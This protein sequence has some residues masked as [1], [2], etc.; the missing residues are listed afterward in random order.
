M[1]FIRHVDKYCLDH[2]AEKRDYEDLMNNPDTQII[3]EKL[4]NGQGA[5]PS[6]FVV[7]YWVEEDLD[8]D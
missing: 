6:V 7:V 3:S 4:V 1:S 8:L 2:P 5:T